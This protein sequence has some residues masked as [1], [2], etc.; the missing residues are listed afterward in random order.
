MSYFVTC[1][2]IR[3]SKLTLTV[4]YTHGRPSYLSEPKGLLSETQ[5]VFL[6]FIYFFFFFFKLISYTANDPVQTLL[7]S[8]KAHISRKIPL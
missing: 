5:Q 7:N 3:R 2:I 8:I 4:K 6:D 1:N